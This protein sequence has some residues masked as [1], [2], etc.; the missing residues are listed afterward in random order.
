MNRDT[1]IKI[2]I[3]CIISAIIGLYLLYQ[4]GPS[5]ENRT[6][7]II[8]IILVAIG[9]GAGK[10]IALIYHAQRQEKKKKK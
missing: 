10:Y 3:A 6:M 4:Y 7:I 1:A 5:G 9:L 8:G 2:V